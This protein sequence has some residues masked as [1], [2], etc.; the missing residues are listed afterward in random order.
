[1]RLDLLL[2]RLRLAKSRAVAQKW[3]GEGH[4]RLNGARVIDSN[5]AIGVGDVL[6]LPFRRAVKVIAIDA[7]PARR[8]PAAEARAHYRELDA[9]N[10]IAIA[11]ANNLKGFLQP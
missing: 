10:P 7:L 3:I 1:M 11:G 6:T 4:M 2:V 5:A 8:G 9:R